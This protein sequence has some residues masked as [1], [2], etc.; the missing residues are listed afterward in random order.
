[1][2]SR[3]GQGMVRSK[4]KGSNSKS[5]GGVVWYQEVHGNGN[6]SYNYNFT[7]ITVIAI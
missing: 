1:M 3:R 4:S 2:G 6:G 5:R 7:I